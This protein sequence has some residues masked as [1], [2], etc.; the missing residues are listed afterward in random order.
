MYCNPWR[1]L[2]RLDDTNQLS[3]PECTPELQE[4]WREVNDPERTR[5]GLKNSFQNIGARHVPLSARL[6][7]CRPNP[8]TASILAIQQ[9]R[10]NRFGIEAGQTTP[11]N[12]AAVM[13]QR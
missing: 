10:A 3:R 12:L 13:D 1:S 5:R 9:G 7:I 8:E 4:S 2:Y 11:N 6:A